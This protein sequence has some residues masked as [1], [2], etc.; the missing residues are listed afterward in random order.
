[1]KRRLFTFLAVVMALFV[2]STNVNAQ[3][4]G[5][6]VF[7][8]GTS[9][10]WNIAAN[11]SKSDGAGGYQTWTSAVPTATDNVW[12]P[13]GLAGSVTITTTSAVCKAL[14]VAGTLLQNIQLTMSSDLA[15]QSTGVMTIGANLYCL[16]INIASSGVLNSSVAASANQNNIFLGGTAG[17]GNYTVTNNGTFGGAVA[18]P[19]ANDGIRIQ[20]SPNSPLVTFK[21]TG[22][23]NI[24]TLIPNSGAYNIDHTLSI[25]QSMTLRRSSGTGLGF[26]VQNNTTFSTKTRTCNILSGVTLTLMNGSNF[27]SGG[28]AAGY[29][30]QQGNIVYNIFGILDLSGTGGTTPGNFYLCTTQYAS[31][32][33]SLTL[34]IGDGTAPNAGTIKF[35]SIINMVKNAG[36]TQNQTI[37]INPKTYST[38]SFGGSTAITW[39]Y[40][41]GGT[42]TPSMFPSSFYNLTINNSVG[43]TLPNTSSV[44]NQLTLTS[45]AFSSGSAWVASTAVTLGQTIYSGNNS[46]TVTTAGTTGASAPTHASGAVVNGTAT[47][48]WVSNTSCTNL[49]VNGAVNNPS[50]FSVTGTTAVNTGAVWTLGGQVTT[51]GNVNIDGQFRGTT[52]AAGTVQT[53]LLQGASPTVTVSGTL[54]GTGV[55]VAGEGLRVYL[56]HTGTATFTGAGTVNIAR[57]HTNSGNSTNQTTNID[58]NMNLNNTVAA[59]SVLT[60]QQANNGTATKVLNI[61]SGKTVTLTQ[62]NGAFHFYQIATPGLNNTGGSMT[63]NIY[64]TLIVSAGQFNLYANQQTSTNVVTVNVKTGGILTL[65]PTAAVYTHIFGQTV[66]INAESGSTVNLNGSSASTIT[67]TTGTGT[68][69]DFI[70]GSGDMIVSNTSGVAINANVTTNNLTLN[71][72][73]T[74]GS[75]KTLTIKGAISGSSTIATNGILAFGGT[76]EQALSSTNIFGT[77]N[78][79]TVNAG[80]K[81]TTA[82]TIS[83]TTLNILNDGTNGTGTLIAGSTL[84]TVISNVSQ[85]LPDARNWYV[86]SPVSNA[87]APNGYTYYRYNEGAANWTSSPVVVGDQLIKGVGYI[88]L[89][90]STASTLIFTTQSGGTLNAGNVDITLSRSGATKTG[91]NLIGNPYPA[92]LTWNKIYVDSLSTLIEPTIWYRTNAGTVNNSGLWSFKTYNA[93]TGEASPLGTTNIIP[94]MQAFWVRALQAGTLTLNSRLVKS[95]Q[96]SNPLKARAVLRSDRQRVRLQVSNGIATDEALVYFDAEATNAY[97]SYDSPKMSNNTASIPEIYTEVNGQKLVING[98]N[99][100][101][102][103]MEIPLG[104]TTGQ[105]NTFTIKAIQ[106]SN[107]DP[108]TKVYLKDNTQVNPLTELVLDQDYTF[109]SDVTADN[110]SRFSLLFKAPTITTETDLVKNQLV[111][112]FGNENNQIVIERNVQSDNAVAYIYNAVGQLMQQLQLNS[113]IT[114]SGISYPCGTYFVTIRGNNKQATS[115]LLINKI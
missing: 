13:T 105:S 79:L 19:T 102:D 44:S 38:V 111:R 52:I 80:S 69:Q 58:I 66:G 113:T 59:A 76:T 70:T 95:H 6:L 114:T 98:M 75:A 22:V 3:A 18:T 54:G 110:T 99:S 91:F 9:L 11:W 31:S 77:I 97:D 29:A 1:M 43:V 4:A 103:N 63:Y 7:T 32:A 92:H 83:A 25:E 35:G 106:L 14:N 16:N 8:A 5:D 23:Y 82:G 30:N 85:Y 64:G 90:G 60:L 72:A 27:H 101:S 41:N 2:V 84:A 33:A 104:F 107:I 94:P 48:T 100:I 28:S 108:D 109:T 12:I 112:V 40:T 93:S 73:F 50:P 10:E 89:P 115:K 15:I 67:S 87:L 51:N 49:V 55:G 17:S 53:W 24:A 78:T 96:S 86:S 62:A 68:I 74:V 39:I 81:L 36:A 46:Y 34:N 65:G 88:A 71:N 61:N 20:Y 37:T 21:G 45:G 56:N 47:L 42:S 26:S 57:L